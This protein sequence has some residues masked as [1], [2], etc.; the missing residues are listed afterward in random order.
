MFR[1]KISVTRKKR[2]IMHHWYRRAVSPLIATIL[3][4]AFAVALATVIIQ[5]EPFSRCKGDEVTIV[6]ADSCYS[7][8][9]P[10][11]RLR[12]QNSDLPVIRF[13]IYLGG[14]LNVSQIP[15]AQPLD[16]AAPAALTIPYDEKINGVLQD[17][18]MV[19]VLN[20]SGTE[21]ECPI[22]QKLLQIRVC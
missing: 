12:V 9:P 20:R 5:L 19:A 7:H 10:S 1:Q 2:S 18:S 4:L 3:L 11:M 17:V 8:D 6:A 16:P 14:S 13:K 22:T 21:M 15:L